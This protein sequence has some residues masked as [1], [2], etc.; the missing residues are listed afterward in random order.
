METTAETNKQTTLKVIATTG[1]FKTFVA[2]IAAMFIFLIVFLV[3]IIAGV[4]GFAAA[5]EPNG[6]VNTH[7]SYSGSNATV[8][9]LH[10]SGLIDDS[11]ASY[12]EQAIDNI[13]K[14]K[15]IRAVVLRVDSPGGGVTASDEIWHNIQRLKEA[16][17]PLIASYGSVAA[18]GGY[19]ISCNADYILAQETTI[20]G[21]IG[22]I[23]SI[24]TFQNL[25]EKIGV[26]PV[27]LIA[28]N[29]P[30][31]SV[32]NDVYRNWTVKDKQKV[33]GI[34]NAMYAVFY[35][36]VAEGRSTAIPDEKKLKAVANGSAYTAQQSLNNGL[37]DGIGYLND[38]IDLA[39]QRAGLT[40]ADATIVHYS[41]A[42]PSFG[43]L[44][45]V[46][47]NNLTTSDIKSMLHEFTMPKLMY[48]YNQ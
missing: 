30:E 39:Q 13:L 15:N 42:T 40:K 25:L 6:T 4:S 27:T 37:I 28:K 21:S 18:S 48:L 7:V 9:V 2:F 19:Y 17:L 34:L 46:Q 26:K 36:R 35:N 12:A 16:K 23:A 11:N 45:G 8:A 24:M 31:K 3:G 32:A 41:R 43:G 22:V 47:S 33:T 38:A 44:L 1:G 10:V 14:D 5:T 29:S 20:T